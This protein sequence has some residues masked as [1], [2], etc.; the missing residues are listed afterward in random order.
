MKSKSIYLGGELLNKTI[1]INDIFK[2]ACTL[3]DEARI[4]PANNKKYHEAADLFNKAGKLTRDW[5]D[6]QTANDLKIYGIALSSYYFY[7]YCD[8]LAS[9]HYECRKIDLTIKHLDEGEEWL[10]TALN[11]ISSAEKQKSFDSKCLSHLLES[12][13]TWEYYKESDAVFRNVALARDRYDNNQ[14]LEALDLYKEAAKKAES[15]AESLQVKTIP[16]SLK[17]KRISN[18]NYIG[19]MVNVS[20]MFINILKEKLYQ[21]SINDNN[22]TY[23]LEKQLLAHLLKAY[24]F[25]KTAFE[26]NPEIDQYSAASSSLLNNIKVFLTENKKLWRDIYIDFEKDDVV[27][28]MMKKIDNKA[29]KKVEKDLILDNKAIKLWTMGS[30]FILLFVIIISLL[31][32]IAN[33]INSLWVFITIIFATEVFLLLIGG[34]L[35]RS[36]GD[37]TEKGFLDLIK[38]AFANQFKLFHLLNKNNPPND[39]K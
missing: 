26:E 1:E 23:L 20:Y 11:S 33:I 35:A 18:G 21:N 10:N 31:C 16:S 9:F 37:L 14:Y 27:K 24:D 13:E 22:Y 34:L 6:K 29:F 2:T 39:P 25:S 28:Q 19:M 30:F 3:K 7:E 38:I 32:F 5:S 12:K 4:S 15:L 36:L 17:L 8:C